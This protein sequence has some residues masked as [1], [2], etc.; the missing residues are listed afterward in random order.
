MS[1]AENIQ[2]E[3]QAR[4]AAAQYA[5]GCTV[6]IES[7]YWNGQNG[8]TVIL[9]QCRAAAGLIVPES[10]HV[11]TP[12]TL[13]AVGDDSGECSIV[14]TVRVKPWTERADVIAAMRSVARVKTA[15]VIPDRLARATYG[16]VIEYLDGEH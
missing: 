15:G 10:V 9:D 7:E 6:M 13:D 12:G 3:K 5:N 8:R 2:A 14:W 1:I 16:E 11:L 4:I